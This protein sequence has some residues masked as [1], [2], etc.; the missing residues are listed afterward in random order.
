MS[1]KQK[2][3][4]KMIQDKKLYV[5][6]F[7]EAYKKDSDS[8]KENVSN[9]DAQADLFDKIKNIGDE[10]TR[11]ELL[12]QAKDQLGNLSG[13]KDKLGDITGGLFN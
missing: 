10:N 6:E 2:V 4:D 7:I 11:N 12:K 1:E 5:D 3:I 13:L 8:S 9:K